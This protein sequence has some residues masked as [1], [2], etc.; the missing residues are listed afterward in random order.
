MNIAHRRNPYVSLYL[1]PALVQGA[2]AAA[3]IVRG[4]KQLDDM[5]MDVIIVGR[6]GGSIEDLWA[7]NEEAVAEA[8]FNAKTPVISA[9]GHETDFTIAD[10]VADMRAPTP[11]AAA[12]LS[13]TDVSVIEG[14]I[15]GYRLR[16]EDELRRKL[17]K[18]RD[19][20]NAYLVQFK[21]LNPRTRVE[22][23]RIYVSSLQDKLDMLF[24]NIVASKRH[25]FEM[26][27]SRLKGVS[28]LEKLSQG[29]SYVEKSGSR[30]SGINDIKPKDTIT[31]YFKDGK[32]DAEVK[33][34]YNG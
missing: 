17:D 32:A 26:Y 31:V 34:V 4:I 7:F 12:E 13:V 15:E 18:Y 19:R 11:S 16:L 22:E 20:L 28:P 29:Y 9:V 27:A 8:I 3:S 2:G 6:G 1:Y 10:F 14:K 24:K 5:G 33:E 21:Y 25:Q 30:V 23:N